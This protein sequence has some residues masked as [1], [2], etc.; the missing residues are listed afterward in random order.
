MHG[1]WQGLLANLAIVSSIVA[2]WA[3]LHEFVGRFGRRVEDVTFGLVMG[4]GA[5]LAM[6]LAFQLEPGM[7]FD[8]R[9]APLAVAGFFGGPGAAL[10]ALVPA[11]VFRMLIGGSGT[12]V[13]CMGMTAV[14]AFALFHHRL[15]GRRPVRGRD[16]LLLALGCAMANLLSFF[17]LPTSMVAPMLLAIALP[18]ASLNFCGV[19][20]AGLSLFRDKR[21]R[22]LVASNALHRATIE[23]LPDC[24]NV[25]DV[26]GRFMAAN[27]ATARLMRAQSTE[28]LIGKSDFDFYPAETAQR[29]R[30][31]EI[32]VQQDN[33]EATIEQKA[34]YPDGTMKWLST[35]KAPL[36]DRAGRLLGLITHNRDITRQKLL[37]IELQKTRQQL[38][39]ALEHMADGLV[40]YDHE[41]RV[42][43]CNKRLSELFPLTADQQVPGALL[44]DI[45]RAGLLRGEQHL[46]NG[47]DADTWIASIIADARAGKDR[48]VAM[49]NGRFF[50]AKDRPTADGGFL[51]IISDVTAEK[52]RERDLERRAERDPLTGLANRS[53]FG[54]RL[55]E[56][57][58]NATS[59]GADFSVML[60]DLDYF[61]Q[62]NDSFGHAAGDQLLVE[63]ARRLESTCRQSDLV[64]RLGGDEF[65]LLAIS[66]QAEDGMRIL[67]ER[68]LDAVT[69][70]L[71]VGSVTILPSCSIGVTTFSNDPSE[72]NSLL[73]HA[74]EALYAAKA[75]GR[76][77]WAIYK[78]Y[79]LKD[80]ATG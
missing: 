5:A 14:T 63:V 45:L 68:V 6:T 64:A 79:S 59:N 21:I 8:L 13:G 37:S 19:A 42:L 17:A 70:P 25:K 77:T 11:L 60:I 38:T 72:H 56:L 58:H 34:Y 12:F 78:P 10:L 28:D 71:N 35:L 9:A 66:G 27:P 44:S 3:N 33:R 7:I 15:V 24:L 23:A 62:V 73:L 67:A 65:A 57:H 31:E 49:A 47:M 74:D 53:A 80:A 51:T 1:V 76:R 22:E 32:A 26:D 20:L 36:R 52:A 69:R 16:V 30:A 46:P 18:S 55:A 61:K 48:L 39:D 29:F 2:V 50:A 4:A 40:M 75:K 43:L 41:N 54:A